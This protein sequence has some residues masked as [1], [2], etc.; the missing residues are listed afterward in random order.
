MD[1]RYFPKKPSAFYLF[2]YL[3]S[4]YCSGMLPDTE[5]RTALTAFGL[6]LTFQNWC[7]HMQIPVSGCTGVF[8]HV[9][10]AFCTRSSEN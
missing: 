9:I 8:V 5:R 3:G 6:P 4:L 1:L 2:V 7:V 10:Y